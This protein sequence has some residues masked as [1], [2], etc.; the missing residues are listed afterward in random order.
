MSQGVEFN[1]LMLD[2]RAMQMDA[3]SMPKAAAAP[4][5]GSSNFADML[6]QAINK[7][8]D[9]Q[10]ASTQLANAFEIGKS[11]VDLTDVMIASQKASVS[12][13]ALTQVRNKLVQAYQDIMQMPV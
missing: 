5:L 12:F 4:E 8:S 3:M 13:Q 10:Q 11:G 2:M 7:V 1:R 6:G 9:T